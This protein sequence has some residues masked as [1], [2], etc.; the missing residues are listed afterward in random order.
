MLWGMSYFLS[1]L[2]PSVLYNAVFLLDDIVYLHL[3]TAKFLS[4]RMVALPIFNA[5]VNLQCYGERH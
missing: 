4:N 5:F 1:A 2:A 3:S